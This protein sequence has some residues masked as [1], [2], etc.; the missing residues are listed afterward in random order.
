[1]ATIE[2]ALQIAIKAHEHQK[3]RYGQ[4]Y[5]FHPMRLMIQMDTPEEKIAAILHDTVEDS[6]IT[7]QDLANK[8]FSAT[9][10]QTVDHLTRRKEETYSEYINRLK[11]HAMAR[12]IKIAD[13]EDN[14]DLRRL[15]KFDDKSRQRL[16]RYHEAWLKLKAL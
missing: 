2:H 4:P 6:D 7:L 3:D 11:D 14:M 12:K 15:T 16:E 5:I 8:G 13:L 9:V 1:M 10:L